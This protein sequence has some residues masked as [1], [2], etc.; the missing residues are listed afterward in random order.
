[1]LRGDG[2]DELSSINRTAASGSRRDCLLHYAGA[3]VQI[4]ERKERNRQRINR[5]FDYKQRTHRLA[6]LQKKQQ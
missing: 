3:Q 6:R 2:Y 5:I 4:R 1:M